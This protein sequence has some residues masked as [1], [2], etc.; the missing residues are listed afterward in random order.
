MT[1]Y[2]FPALYA[3]FVWWF[4]TGAIM[5]LDGLPKT[6]FGRSMLVATGLA[7]LALIG[8]D[9]SCESATVAGAYCAF[10]CAIVIWGWIEV[11]F[12]LGFVTGPRTSAAPPGCSEW[13]RFVHAVGAIAY[14]EFAIVVAAAVII[15]LTDGA[16]NLVGVWTFMILW[17]MRL[18]AKLN[19]F[20]GVRNLGEEFL[21]ERMR[22]LRSFFLKRPMNLLFPVSV[23]AATILAVILWKEAGAPTASAFDTAG[24]TLVATLLSL[25]IL[26]HWFM[27]LPLPTTALWSWGLR[28]RAGR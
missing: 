6:T 14:H 23:T 17:V 13:Q 16:P 4:T 11:A 21:P 15:T 3:M 10:T 24:L 2:G 12:L 22:Y 25:A 9:R 27:V 20:L 26:E 19:L 1:E 7:L 5:F 8:L 18:S 28:S